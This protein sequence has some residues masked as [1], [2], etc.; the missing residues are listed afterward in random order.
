MSS[1]TPTPSR[2]KKKLIE[3]QKTNPSATLN[4]V[5]K[6]SQI[7]CRTSNKGSKIV[8]MEI[9]YDKIEENII[10]LFSSIKIGDDEYKNYTVFINNELKK[11]T[12]AN[13][14]KNS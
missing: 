6:P 4:D 2:F 1:Y 7:R 14:E 10:E 11:Q 3:L 5:T 8:N 12:K 13:M 9:T